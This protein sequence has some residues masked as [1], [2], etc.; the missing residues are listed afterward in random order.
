MATFDRPVTDQLVH[1]TACLKNLKDVLVVDVLTFEKD[2]LLY[3]R[4]VAESIALFESHLASVLRTQ[5][6]IYGVFFDSEVDDEPAAV[7]ETP[8]ADWPVSEDD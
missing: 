6:D 7:E 1:I 8:E 3:I 2:T 5:F 4:G